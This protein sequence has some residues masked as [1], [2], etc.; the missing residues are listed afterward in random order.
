MRKR[1]AM[2]YC[3][4][5]TALSA[6]ATAAGAADRTA[7]P[8]YQ[9]PEL[10]HVLVESEP[11]GKYLCINPGVCEMSD[12]SLLIVY[13]RTT[14][15]DWGGSYDTYT[16]VSRD[17]GK[18][19]SDAH[20]F[21]KNMQAPGL[22]RLR[23]GDVLLWGSA[24]A[25]KLGEE[26]KDPNLWHSTTMSLFR[27]KNKGVT[28]T[29]ERPIWEH[30]K[31]IRLQGGCAT[32]VQLKSGRL[33][34]PFHYGD[35]GNY[36]STTQKSACYYSDDEGKTWTEGRAVGLPQHGA[37]SPV[38]AEMNDG[39]LLMAVRTGLGT[40]YLSRSTDSGETWAPAWSSGLEMTETDLFMTA[41]PDGSGALLFITTAKYEPNHHHGGERTP[42][43]AF[44]SKDGGKT[45]RKVDD[46]AGGSG[47]EMCLDSMCF[48][49][50][51]K[52]A[53]TYEFRRV[54]WSRGRQGGGGGV[55]FVLADR[56]WF[57]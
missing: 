57:D 1:D 14:E 47:H 9:N 48:L 49:S 26:I 17:G 11:P 25:A 41:F 7:T 10:L 22:L 30:S 24:L 39:S 5:L 6:L 19:W 42:I 18:T 51:G 13:H 45:W 46:V 16:R 53:M 54:A 27:S 20:L 8:T 4:A 36:N 37:A 12:G 44:V 52:V 56:K 55:W 43:T 2:R 38:V 15:I 33:L 23:S 34:F 31:G 40:M 3:L 35:A 28:W 29:Q 32:M 50:N 21:A